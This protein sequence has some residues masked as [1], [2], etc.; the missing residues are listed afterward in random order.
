M[1]CTNKWILGLVLFGWLAGAALAEQFN[2]NNGETVIGELLTGSASDQGV[3]IKIGEGDYKRVPW[4]SFPQDVLKNFAKNQ[5]L[6]QFVEPF[7]EVSQ[8]ERIKKTEAPL[9]TPPRLE[10]P[11]PHSL[12]G[13]MFSSGLGLF[14]LAALYAAN[15]YAGFE[16]AIFRAR[17]PLT[18]CGLCAVPG[19]GFFVPIAFLAMP[20][21][22][23]G[24]QSVVE[25]Q[26]SAA[27]AGAPT[28][29]AGGAAAAD[30]DI[31]PMRDAHVA[32]P[33]SLKLHGEAESPKSAASQQ[34]PTIYQR[35][36]F[37]FNRRFFETKFPGFF[38]VVRREADRDQILYIKSARGEYRGTRISRIAAA[39]L[40]LEVHKGSATEEVQIPFQEINEVQLKHKDA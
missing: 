4:A 19:L 13:A 31:N 15:I 23:Q 38:G 36:Q 6:A 1:V 40:H 39:D 24:Q 12:I 35:G 9:K 7:I 30:D 17:P 34:K 18:V 29:A 33:S 22:M 2:L 26:P 11:T 10:R 3:Q 5:R 8:D 14:I 28:A 20:T 25:E 27:A 32:H 21:R 16:V 37:T